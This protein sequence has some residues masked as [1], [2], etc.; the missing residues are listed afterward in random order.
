[1]LIGIVI[2]AIISWVVATFGIQVFHYYERSVR[3]STASLDGVTDVRIPQ[4]R[5][6]PP[7]D[8]GLYSFRGFIRQI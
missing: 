5:I 6:C 1:M 3:G 2:I 8:R 4:I 7:G